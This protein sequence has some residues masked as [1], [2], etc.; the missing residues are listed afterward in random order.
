MKIILNVI[1]RSLRPLV[2]FLFRV[3]VVGQDNAKSVGAKT[4]IVANHVSTLDGFFLFLFLADIPTFAVTPVTA[5]TPWIRLFLR[6]VKTIELDPL[7]PH[8]IKSVIRILN[9]GDQALIFPEGRVTT[10]GSLM[11]IYEGPAMMAVLSDATI[12]PVGIEGLQY[13]RFSMLGR[14]VRQRWFPPV[15][16]TYLEPRKINL[17]EELQG[18]E[19]RAKASAAMSHIMREIAY[20]NAFEPVTFYHAV[21]NAMH[22]HGPKREI[23]ADSTGANL[24]YRQL[25]LRAG[26]LAQFIA[27]S[28]QRDDC[29]GIML[30]STAAAIVTLT[31]AQSCGRTTAMMNFTAGIRGLIIACETASIKIVITSRTFITQAELGAEA[32]A[33]EAITQVIYLE[34]LREMVSI[35]HKIKAAISAF[36]PLSSYRFR[37]KDRNP[38]NDCVILFT[39]GSEGIPKGVVLTHANIIANR[40]QVQ[41]LIALTHEDTVL[42]V[43]PMFHAFGLLGGTLIPLFDGAKIYCYPS[44]LHY[45]VIPE[46]SYQLGATCLFGTNTFLSGYAKYGHPYDFHKLRFVI[47]GAEKLTEQTRTT[48]AEKFGIRIYEGYGATEASPVITVN[49]PMG[50]K[51]DT[52]GQLLA[53]MD[54]YLEPVEGIHSGGRLVVRGPNVMRGYLFHGG[55]GERY[56]P[57]TDYGHGWYDTGDIVTV[58]DDGFIA[59]V[60]RLKR[61]AKIGG[62]MVS[63]SQTEEIAIAA[64]PDIAHAAVALPSTRKGEQIVLLSEFEQCDRRQ[65]IQMAKEL[66]IPELS[67]PKRVIYCEQIPLL[68]SGKVDYPALRELAENLTG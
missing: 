34:D 1:R 4:L 55:D 35:S 38:D 23:I 53:K 13:S 62:E 63:L 45:R 11:K 37:H 48:W 16:I 36:I 65:L 51:P 5:R 21:V 59:I 18:H 47:A 42:N 29:V 57:S 61:F 67:L 30:P 58:D 6:F 60:G 31:A 32:S 43:L 27:K 50:C 24:T 28:T 56:P 52:V 49:T 40:A 33:I 12:L 44:P 66:G 26:V 17:A 2:K 19:R 15:T 14:R 68:G 9:N 20:E 3:E 46:L 7:S 64:W 22:R 8:A 41:T 10:S 25:L 39:S 54:Y